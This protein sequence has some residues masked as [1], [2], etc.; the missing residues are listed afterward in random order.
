MLPQLPL[1]LRLSEAQSFAEFHPGAN[2]EVVQALQQ[3][4]SNQGDSDLLFLWGDPGLGKTHLLQACCRLAHQYGHQI[5]YL[6]L[7]QIAEHGPEFLNGLESMTFVAM[8]DLQFLAGNRAWERAL[9]RSFNRW[10]EKGTRV[11]FAA[12]QPPTHLAIQMPDLKSR[13]AWGLTLRLKPFND[14]DKLAAIQLRASRLGFEVSP[15]VG[16]FLLT[17]YSRDLSVIWK[18]MQSLDHATLAAKRKLTIPFLKQFLE[19]Q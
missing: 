2:L 8:D 11:I 4:A 18:L 13:L 17:H 12:S 10:R 3:C 9:F 7:A 15:Q 6:P 1:Q 19:Q 5:G 14:S 16:K